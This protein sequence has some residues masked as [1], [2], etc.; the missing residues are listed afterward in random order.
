[1]DKEGAKN[2]MDLH[3]MA[4]DADPYKEPFAGLVKA[5]QNKM[6]IAIEHGPWL[7]E[8][9]GQGN[10]TPAGAMMCNNHLPNPSFEDWSAG[11]NSRI[12]P[13]PKE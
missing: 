2:D 6:T 13:F 10:P 4:N 3:L 11:I 1:M 8:P 7:E 5:I 9:P 12:D